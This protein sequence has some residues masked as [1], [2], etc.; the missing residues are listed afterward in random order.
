MS[1]SDFARAVFV[2]LALMFLGFIVCG[3]AVAGR[4]H[5]GLW[6][7]VLAF[8]AVWTPLTLRWAWLMFRKGD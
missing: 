3:V 5:G 7:L 2:W 1:G 6:V 4:E 8:A